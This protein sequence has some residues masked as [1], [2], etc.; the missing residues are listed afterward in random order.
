[1]LTP[2]EI[3]SVPVMAELPLAKAAQQ[4]EGGHPEDE[5]AAGMAERQRARELP[6]AWG[7]VPGCRADQADHDEDG[8]V[9][10]EEVGRD[11]EHPPGLADAA[12]VAVG[13]D[14]HERDG[15]R[16]GTHA[17]PPSAGAAEMMASAPAATDTATV[18][19]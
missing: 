1:M 9:G 6:A 14:H 3:A 4:E 15:H 10:D 16:H 7:R 5:A 12:Q 13:E 18:M 2:L 17:F 19:V 8:H 11:G